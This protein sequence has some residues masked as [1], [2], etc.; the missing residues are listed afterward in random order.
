VL[1]VVTSALL[2]CAGGC[3]DSAAAPLGPSPAVSAMEADP[4]RELHGT[5]VPWA[6]QLTRLPPAQAYR[7]D[8]FVNSIGINTHLGYFDTPYGTDYA[9]VVRPKLLGLGVR[10]VRDAGVVLDDDRWMGSLY[11]RMKDLASRGIKFTLIMRPREGGAD[12]S[13]LDHLNRLLGFAAPVIEGFEGL[14]EHDLAGRPGW[15]AEVRAFQKALFIRV[16]GDSRTA[17]LPV[18]GPSMGN[19]Y[20]AALVGDLSAWMDF[21]VVHPYS[22]G[23]SP[24]ANLGDHVTRL[25]A[26]NRDRPL[27]ATETGYQTATLSTSDHPPVTERA[28]ARYVPRIFLEFFTSGVSR[29]FLYE[30][31][32]QGSDLT[33]QEKNFGLIR[34]DGSEKPAYVALKNLISVLADPGPA[35][36]PGQLRY[37]VMGDTSGVRRLLLTK[38]DGRFYLVLWLDA[39]SYDLAS[40]ADILV[41]DKPLTLRLSP[42]AREVRV[43][44]PLVSASPLRQVQKVTSLQVFVSDSPVVIEILP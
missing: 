23:K 13:S 3:G 22:G 4:A 11:D 39:S 37:F 7:A 1:P 17:A 36:V 20:H 29:T 28:M 18:L 31:L 35:F 21:G 5:M 30:L 9:T 32:D 6:I 12:Y 2:L 24:L 43:I 8:D 19:P 27:V 42:A 10:H 15:A 33:E 38:R 14:N 41:K 25:G 16:K 44:A 26:V 40:K 34:R